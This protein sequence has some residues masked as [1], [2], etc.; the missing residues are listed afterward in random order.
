MYDELERAIIRPGGALS[1]AD[2][3]VARRAMPYL[4]AGSAGI[5]LV[6]TRFVAAAPDEL[7]VASLPRILD[8]VSK[9][10]TIMPG[11][12]GGL[13]GLA[14]VLA[15]HAGLDGGCCQH[16]SAISL[17]TGLVTHAVPH[18]TGVRFLG[19]GSMRYSAELWSGS[20][21]VLLAL[22]RVLYGAADLFFTLDGIPRRQAAASLDGAVLAA[23]IPGTEGAAPTFDLPARVVSGSDHAHD[24]S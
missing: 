22:H 18:A 9:R 15:D 5:A 12:Y 10:C 17:A 1:F 16:D 11:L 13:A 21:G 8:D 6:L 23:R 14:F 7:F 20:A 4:Y 24:R 2:D 19:D 3:A